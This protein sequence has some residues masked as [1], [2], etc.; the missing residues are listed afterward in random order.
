MKER[1]PLPCNI[2]QTLNI[3]GD[4]WTLLI[5]HEILIGNKTFN[6]IKHNLETVSANLL[7]TRL[8]TLEA[9][10][11]VTSE[12]YS[13]HP[14]R[15]QY[16]LTEKGRALEPVFHAFLLWGRDHLDKCYKKLVDEQTGQEVSIGFF[17]R[18][19]GER[20]PSDQLQVLP[21]ERQTSG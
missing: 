9:E 17:D 5:I 4:R 16:A 3:V 2:A 19:S 12:L 18:E 8:K 20:I 7:S 21:Y 13:K 1:Y 10:G 15:Y 14:P 11:M 6:D